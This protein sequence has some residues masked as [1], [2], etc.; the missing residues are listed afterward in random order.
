MTDETSGIATHE[1]N[2]GSAEGGRATFFACMTLQSTAPLSRDESYGILVGS[3]EGGA[4]GGFSVDTKT[5]RTVTF[6]GQYVLRRSGETSRD[7]YDEIHRGLVKHFGLV[8]PIT[9]LHW[10]LDP[11]EL[12]DRQQSSA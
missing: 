7:V 3:S 12:P 6:Q 1:G 9:T 2:D 11:M 5:T 8:E 10:S 4:H